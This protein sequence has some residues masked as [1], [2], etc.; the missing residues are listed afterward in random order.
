MATHQLAKGLASLGRHGD[1][2]LLHVS[3]SEV[4]GL[5][6][7]GAMTGRKVSTNPHTGMPEAF[8]F[9]DFFS[10][11]IPTGIG[12]LLGGPAGAAM[13]LEKG[14]MLASA[15]PVLGG[16]AAGA[17]VAGAKGEDPLLGGIMGGLGGYGG[18]NL[19]KTF[20]GMGA[21][22]AANA[23]NAANAATSAGGYT[24]PAMEEALKKGVSGPMLP[25]AQLAN[26]NLLQPGTYNPALSQ[27]IPSATVATM[28][29]AS[30]NL[31]N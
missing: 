14:T 9:G 25:N 21:N 20:T 18:G 3:P 4:E 16:M 28:P 15:A 22:A 8:S 27:S 30:E 11:L 19:A 24:T 23:A 29:T 5:K 31:I 6:A 10:S 17:A 13:G 1:S 12:F 2:M 26:T 7:L